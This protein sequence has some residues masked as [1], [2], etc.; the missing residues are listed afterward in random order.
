M[1]KAETYEIRVAGRELTVRAE[2]LPPV[3]GTDQTW[4]ETVV[5]SVTEHG[6]ELADEVFEPLASAIERAVVDAHCER[7]AAA[8]EPERLAAC[9]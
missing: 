9:G 8:R 3:R 4:W 5:S 1:P 2:V 7:R 6:V